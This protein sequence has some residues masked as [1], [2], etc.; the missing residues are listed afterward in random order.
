MWKHCFLLLIGLGNWYLSYCQVSF[1][2]ESVESGILHSHV[3]LF[4]IGGGVAIVDFDN[5]GWEDVYFTGG[6]ESDKLYKNLGTGQFQDVSV[7]A[8]IAAFSEVETSGVTT[9]DIDNDGFREILVTSLLGDPNLLLYNNGDGTFQQIPLPET[10]TEYWSA[11]AAFGDVNKD[12]FLDILIG[13]YIYQ[14][15]FIFENGIVVGF[16]HQ[17]SPNRLYL[18]NGD[19]TFTDVSSSYGIDDSGCALAVAFTNYDNDADVDIIVSNDFGE[20]GQPNQLFENDFPSAFF[21]NASAPQNMDFSMYGMGIAIGDYDKDLDLDYYQT[22]IGQNRLSKNEPGGF[23][24][25]TEFAGVENDSLDGLNTT[26]WGTFFADLD[27]DTWLDLFVS[28]G[29]IPAADLIANVLLDPNKLYHNSGDG[30]FDDITASANIGSVLKGR[31]AA[32]GDLNKD[33]KLD[34]LIN[35]LRDDQEQSQVSLFT[36]TTNNTNHWLGIK[37]TG[38]QSNRDAFG[39]HVKIVLGN[40][41]WIQELSGGSSHASQNSSIMHFGLG[42]N[43]AADSIIVI[44][45]SGYE[46]ILTNVSADQVITVVED[47]LTGSNEPAAQRKVDLIKSNYGYT[48]NITSTEREESLSLDYIDVAGRLVKTEQ[49]FIKQGNNQHLL[50]PPQTK[51][52]Y[53]LSIRGKYFKWIERII[54][55]E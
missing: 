26:S 5:D 51:G 9:G 49:V 2:E 41:S 22:N 43:T 37:L 40:E 52:I 1:I 8:G 24:D 42:T 27:N 34:I 53:L 35:N 16:N 7:A 44:F 31:G 25:V 15:N 10:G 30:T 39:S 19:L 48:L 12:G 29:V 54:L 11:A 46:T 13:N 33:G 36:N 4:Q 45:P 20:W 47:V 38:V 21:T 6:E 28:N 3:H 14:S 55:P 23:E 50:T 17:C 32:Y 18:N